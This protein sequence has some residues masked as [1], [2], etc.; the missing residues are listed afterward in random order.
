[1]ATDEAGVTPGQTF[2][3]PEDDYKGTSAYKITKL[4]RRQQSRGPTS[5]LIR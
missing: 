3:K 4:V 5:S 2:V 1:M